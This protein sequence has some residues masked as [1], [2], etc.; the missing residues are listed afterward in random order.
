MSLIRRF[1]SQSPTYSVTDNIMGKNTRQILARFL[2]LC[3][4]LCLTALWLCACGANTEETPEISD[5]I[6]TKNQATDITQDRSD[7]SGSESESSVKTDVTVS[8]MDSSVTVIMETE[9]KKLTTEDGIIYLTLRCTY[10]I[11]SIE[12]NDTA[13]ENINTDIWS[14]IDS[15]YEERAYYEDLKSDAANW[16]GGSTNYNRTLFYSVKRAD[17]KVIS[18]TVHDGEYTGGLHSMSF[19]I[20]V[21][22]DTE[23]GNQIAFEN[24]SDD[25]D[26]FRAATLAYNTELAATDA[27]ERRMFPQDCMTDA[28]ESVLYEDDVWYLSTYGLSFMSNPYMLG[29]YVAGTIEFIIPYSALADMGFKD[30]YAY[31]DRLIVKLPD[32]GSEEESIDLNNDGINDAVVSYYEFVNI[33]AE[34]D[35]YTYRPHFTVNGT[36]FALDGS[37]NVKEIPEDIDAIYLYDLDVNDSYVEL[38][39]LSWELGSGGFDKYS[40]FFRYTEDGSL[41]YL[42]RMK[43]D[44][45][46]PTTS[47]SSSDLQRES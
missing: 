41:V 38:V 25:P 5:S 32:I 43:G 36:D 23:T 26:A 15:F 24:L 20:G 44:V 35:T 34:N 30:V 37:D 39:T 6:A 8:I 19:E 29:S 4:V 14:H 12:G 28:L 47:L 27:Y 22:Y 10:P 17:D 7:N 46:D 9:E 3:A 11:V 21:N 1:L 40:N 45:T 31:T 33:D 16:H 2:P 42:G 18:F 13:A